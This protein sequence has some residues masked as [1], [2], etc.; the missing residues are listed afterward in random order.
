[1]FARRKEV[2]YLCC[3][4]CVEMS[5][6][7]RAHK[8][9]QQNLFNQKGLGSTKR[10]FIKI[11][12]VFFMT[13]LNYPR[14]YPLT[15]THIFC[16]SETH[17]DNSTPT[18]LFEIPGYTFINKNRDVGTHGG[19][20]IYIKDGIPFIRRTDLEVNELECIWLE[21]NFPNTSFLISVWYRPPSTSKF[22][23]TNF[24]KLFLNSL[25]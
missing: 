24:N 16:L 9:K 7:S 22:L 5:R 13:L 11:Y 4:L 17:I 6:M 8:I 14:F 21:I 2:F 18:Q 23:T 12:E 1:M 19:V 20:A 3:C 25:I 15:K 10:F